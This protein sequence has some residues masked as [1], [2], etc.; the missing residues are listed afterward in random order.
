MKFVIPIENQFH[1][2]TVPRNKDL[3]LK[4][5]YHCNAPSRKLLIDWK[6]DCFVCGCELWLPISVG[7]ITDFERL[8]DVWASPTAQALQQSIDRK[9][10]DNCA[11]TRCGVMHYDMVET[12]YTISINIDESCNLHCPSCRTAPVM[13]TSGSRHEEKLVWVNH[14]VD[15]LEQFEQPCRIIMSGNGDP[16]AS[17]IMRPLLH[18]YKP[19][20]KQWIKLFTNGLLLRKQLTDNPVTAH[21][22]EYLISIDAGSPE[23]YEQVRLGGRWEQLIDNFIFLK[24]HIPPT[25]S[26]GSHHN[27][28]LTMV[29]QKNNYL[30]MKNFCKLCLYFGFVGSITKLEDWGTWQDFSEHDVLNPTHSE[31][32]TAAQFLRETYDEYSYHI[33]FH[34]ALQQFLGVNQHVNPTDNH[35]SVKV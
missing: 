9:T 8:E 12:E 35:T 15:M 4:V 19:R 34:S 2:D 11:V 21:I 23:V 18:R 13:I 24:D 3:K 31:H 30:D 10:F 17:S 26:E 27:V 5:D 29:M 25:D 28:S 6:G 22:D 14:L 33:F 20:E 32:T 7:K 1:W 16:L